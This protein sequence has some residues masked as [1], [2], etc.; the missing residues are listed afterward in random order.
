MAR[1]PV[2]THGG[3]FILEQHDYSLFDFID[4]KTGIA[5]ENI[6]FHE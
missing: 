3:T 2:R 5:I 4:M 1:G 6:V